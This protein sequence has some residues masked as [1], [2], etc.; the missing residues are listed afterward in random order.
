M[1][2]SYHIFKARA[3][4]KYTRSHQR[5]C[6]TRQQEKKYDLVKPRKQTLL[7]WEQGSKRIQKISVQT[8]EKEQKTGK[9]A[10]QIRKNSWENNRWTG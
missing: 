2:Q 5:Y 3:F 1:I 10:K 7:C 9:S 4:V 8:K 6:K